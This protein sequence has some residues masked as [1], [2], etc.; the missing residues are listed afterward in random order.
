MAVNSKHAEGRKKMEAVAEMTRTSALANIH[1][2]SIDRQM[3][4]NLA[5][6]KIAGKKIDLRLCL[7]GVRGSIPF[8]DRPGAPAFFAE[9]Q[10]RS[11]KNVYIADEEIAIK[12][13]WVWVWGLVGFFSPPAIPGNARGVRQN[14]GG[15]L[16]SKRK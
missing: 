10:S 2:H 11:L 4:I 14:V 9:C 15:P 6:T 5:A 16:F 7:K 1:G 12:I 13:C 3:D 8:R